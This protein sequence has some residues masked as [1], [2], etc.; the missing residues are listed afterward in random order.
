MLAIRI[1]KTGGP[2]VLEA[3]ETPKPAPAAGQILVRQEAI[4][5]NFVDTYMRSGLYPIT[6]PVVLGGEGSGVVEAVGEGVTRFRPG[7]RVGYGSGGLGAYAEFYV[8]SQDRAALLPSSMSTKTA[9]AAMLKGMTAEFLLRRC[10][11]LKAGEPALIWAASGGVGLILTQWAKAIG[12][13]TI[14]CVGSPEKAEVA[15]A[16]G[17][18]HV[19]LY[20]SEDVPARVREITDGKGVRV[21]YDGVGKASFEASLKSLGRRGMLV[22]FGNASGP[23]P[24][25]E[26]LALSRGGS[27]FLTR[28]TL[29]DYI[30]TREEHDEA[31]GALF[32]V[33][34]SG[35]VKIEIGREFPLRDARKAHEAIQSGE[36]VGSTLL[37]P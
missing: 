20:K 25:I 34:Q 29:Y 33:I 1:S 3:V 7:D 16:H 22:T 2:E 5:L 9:A 13:L 6:P 12:A 30:T 18:D 26:P 14:G 17:C 11:P 24:P 31:A 27:L 8:V 23:V 32:D 36:T 35:K 19:I 21:S 15:R 10:Y 4:G 37:I 28:P